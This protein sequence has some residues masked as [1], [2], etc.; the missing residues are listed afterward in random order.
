MTF[1]SIRR[2]I[3]TRRLGWLLALA[4]WL[5]M[6]QWAVATHTLLHLHASVSEQHDRPAQLPDSCETCVVAAAVVG[7]GPIAHFTPPQPLQLPQLPPQGRP[8]SLLPLP[9]RVGYDSRA[10]PSLHA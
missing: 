10:P 6:A 7:A 2:L 1:A 8:T 9:P 4:L 5:P 3:A